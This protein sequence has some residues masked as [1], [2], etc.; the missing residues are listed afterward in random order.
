MSGEALFLVCLLFTDS[1]VG[2]GAVRTAAVAA[3]AVRILTILE[4]SPEPDGTSD[5][6]EDDN[7]KDY[8][9]RYPL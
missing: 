4:P 9:Y 1:F 3:A 7:R 5:G 6:G 2:K 8:R